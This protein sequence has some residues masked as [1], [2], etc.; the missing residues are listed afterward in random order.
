MSR[1]SGY[2][3]SF[4][5]GSVR[6]YSHIMKTFDAREVI[7]FFYFEEMPYKC[8]VAGC[9]TEKLTNKEKVLIKLAKFPHDEELYKKWIRAA[10][11]KNLENLPMGE[12]KKNL[13]MCSRHF[14]QKYIISSLSSLSKKRFL[15]NDAVPT[16]HLTS[17]KFYMQ[18]F[19]INFPLYL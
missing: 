1:I 18:L 8:S 10:G 2:V 16:L 17:G 5:F 9:K 19:D 14:E 4:M 13:F 7:N 12:L 6:Y 11:N 3:D 15:S